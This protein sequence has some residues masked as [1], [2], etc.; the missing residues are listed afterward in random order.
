MPPDLT[1]ITGTGLGQSPDLAQKPRLQLV[2]RSVLV[3]DD[4]PSTRELLSE[5]L[6]G[7]GY[8]TMT[9]GS[10]EE[11]EFAVKHRRFDAA[12]VDIFLPGKSGTAL[13]SRLRARFPEAVLIGISALGDG[14]VARRCKGLGADLF[15]AKPIE[16]EELSQALLTPHQSWH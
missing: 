2:R 11:A 16:P 3:V 14:S 8:R 4:D 13:F 6:G 12:I 15:L 5:L 7:W 1:D 9:V 10:A